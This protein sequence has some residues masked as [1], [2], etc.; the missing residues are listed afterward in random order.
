MTLQLVVFD[1]DG[2]LVDTEPAT[3]QIIA[4][5]F[6]RHGLPLS[7][8]QVADLFTG[9]TM[10]DV[11]REGRARGAT[12]PATWLPDIYAE[13]YA[14][15]AEGVDVFEGV[16][17]LLDAL[18][19]RAVP[20]FVA[21]NGTM[22]KMRT[23]LGPSGLWDRFGGDTGGRILSREDHAP[24]PDPAIILYALAQTGADPNCAVMID[25][26]TAGCKAGIAAGVRTIGFATEDQGATLAALGAEVATSMAEVKRL[27]LDQ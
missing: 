27:I 22:Q 19:A 26:S 13:I 8:D 24:K 16:F 6:T 17:D 11:E 21:S 4:A 2:V 10:N 25:D 5:S 15:L 23:S 7:P 20:C 1:C 9:G 18:D 3:A 14:R 12:L